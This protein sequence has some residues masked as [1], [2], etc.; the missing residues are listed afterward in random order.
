MLDKNKVKKHGNMEKAKS[1]IQSQPEMTFTKNLSFCSHC[2]GSNV[3]RIDV[4]N[5]KIIRIRPLHYDEKY[6]PE[7]FNPWQIKARGKAYQPLMKEPLSP[8]GLS[9]K[10][11]IYSPNRIKYPLQRVDWDPDGERNPQNRG[12]SR[13]KR[14]SWE[15][16]TGIIAGEIKRI[17]SKYGTSAIYLKNGNHGETKCVHGTHGVPARLIK[18]GYTAQSLNPDS[19]EGW[20]WGA[21]HVWGMDC[22]WT[23]AL[24]VGMMAPQT[25]VIKD[26]SE[27]GEMVIFIGCDPETTPMGFLGQAYSRLCYWWQEL[28]IKQVYICPDLN[29]GAA[30]HADKWIPIL[31]NT[32]A[33]LLLAI[34]YMW[35]TEGSYDKDYIATHAYGF[36]KFEDYVLGKE[37]GLS[38]TPKWASQRCGIPSRTIKAL[39]REW[40]S[41]KTSTMHNAGGSYIRGPYAHEPARLE[42]LLLTMQ[43]VGK[44]GVHQATMVD[45]GSTP[46]GVI[47]PNIR[48]AFRGDADGEP[49]QSILK[50]LLHEAILNPPVS[51]YSSTFRGL[52]DE[53]FKQYHYPLE[54][55]SEIHMIWSD[56]ACFTVCW[57]CGNRMIEAFRSPKIEFV[58]VQHPW[59]EDDCLYGDMILPVNTKFEEKDI[60]TGYSQNY[61]LIFPEGKCIEPVGESKSDYEIVG[62]IAKKLGKYDEFTEGKTIEEWIR[63]GF[64]RSGVASMVSWE[65]FNNK[66][67]YVVPTVKNWEKAPAGMI[68]YY[69]NPEEYPLHT[70][71]GKIEFYGQWL[72]EHFPADTER[73]PVPHWIPEGMTHRENKQSA[74]AV[75]YSLLLISNHPRWRVHAQHDDVTWLREINT[76]KVKGTDGYLYEPVWIN[77]LDAASRGIKNG[78]I[79]KLFN[80]RG[81]VLGGAYITERIIP[82]AVSQDHG[83]RHDPITD[84]LDRGGSN[85]LIC[86]ENTT[87]K[88]ACGM[89]TSGY[90]VEVEKVGMGQMEEWEKRY[91]EAFEREYYPA[92]GIQFNTWI[93][94]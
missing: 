15:E 45:I 59:L 27:N 32:D 53:Q 10:K 85:N 88:N 60:G 56:D 12:I 16:A 57:N 62:E 18:K 6:K 86:P 87:S 7:E 2:N 14:I 26:I 19:W 31:P 36:N 33:A 38:K 23:K 80:D 24:S 21:E 55:A 17:Q 61:D 73:P 72:A 41:K 93:E 82:G 54:G 74:R 13:F 39:A 50:P 29:Y 69:K 65:E 9:Y 3:A 35:I 5:G 92:A 63:F 77:P 81:A 11:R 34:A 46:R 42:V 94:E 66:G 1:S 78:D 28:G 84:R 30:V 58:L 83:A 40:A 67:Y 76:C 68:R 25:N 70:K 37:D 48:P 8:F 52:V 4:K 49:R 51:W 79:V 71:S 43:G 89:A 22:G 20:Y 75:K 44:P 64:D 90:L 91:P 47:I